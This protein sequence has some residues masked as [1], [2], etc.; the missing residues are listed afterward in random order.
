[1]GLADPRTDPFGQEAK[2]SEA[3]NVLA[4]RRHEMTKLATFS[5]NEN[6]LVILW[7]VNLKYWTL[8]R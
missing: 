7:N 2:P 3:R 1:M 8:M 6:R 5:K 4:F